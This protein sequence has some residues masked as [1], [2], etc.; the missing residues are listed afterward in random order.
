MSVCKFDMAIYGMLLEVQ[1]TGN[2]KCAR[3]DKKK[4]RQS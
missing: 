2:R 4:V 3:S 1:E